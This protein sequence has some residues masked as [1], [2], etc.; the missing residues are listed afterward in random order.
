V[1]FC[2]EPTSGAAGRRRGDDVLHPPIARKKPKY[3]ARL[4]PS[5]R[6]KRRSSAESAVCS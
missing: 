3:V 4:R 1:C 6:P 5:W 2:R